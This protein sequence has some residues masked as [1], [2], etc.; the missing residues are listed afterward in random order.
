MPNGLLL[1]RWDERSGVEIKSKYPEDIKLDDMT[2]MQVYSQHEYSQDAGIIS[3]TVGSTNIISYYSG[4]K[5]GLYIL[6]FLNLDEDPDNYESILIEISQVILQNITENKYEPLI[7]IFFQKL[8]LYPNLPEE[9]N[10]IFIYQNEIYNLILN[11]LRDECVADKAELKAW[12]TDKYRR[13]F[14]D[15]ESI[16]IELIK[17]GLIKESS[18]KGKGIPSI[19]ICL[20]SDIIMFRKPPI[21]I[22]EDPV[23]L[24]LPFEFSKIYLKEIS[25]FFENYL[26]SEED[27]R[28][29]LNIFTIPI[30]YQILGILRNEVLSRIELYNQLDYD[31]ED[32]T[33]IIEMLEEIKIIKILRKE[34]S[35]YVVLITDISMQKIFPKYVFNVILAEYNQKS[36]PDQVLSE[37]LNILEGEYKKFKLE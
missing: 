35:E 13:S 23:N 31:K 16:I 19:I 29:I 2:L 18:I 5:K 7:P 37:Y 4:P 22:L 36:K 30:A 24:G 10:L 25:E 27:N 3:L 8:S 17:I 26:P 20:I 11:R 14:I 21:S 6:L 9:Q 12:L 33:Q 28:E 34:D 15:T 1:M 32:I